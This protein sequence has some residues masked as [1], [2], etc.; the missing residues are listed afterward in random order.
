MWLPTIIIKEKKHIEMD[1]IERKRFSLD[2]MDIEFAEE[3]LEDEGYQDLKLTS[4]RK[5]ILATLLYIN[6]IDT[7]DEQGYFF[8]EN[9]YLCKLIGV[10]EPTLID[11]L[12]YFN[13]VGILSRIA[14][15]RGS[16]SL[17]KIEKTL[18]KNFSN[19]LSKN[20]SNNLSKNFSNKS[21]DNQ[22]VRELRTENF[23]NNLSKNFS[24]NFSNK[25][26]NFSTDTDIEEDKDIELD[27]DK[28]KDINKDIE[29]NN[30]NKLYNIKLINYLNNINNNIIYIKEKNIKKEKEIEEIALK[31]EEL[32]LKVDNFI[33]LNNNNKK[34]KFGINMKKENA[35]P[36]QEALELII[37]KLNSIEYRITSIE[38][39]IKT[40]KTQNCSV[41]A[42]NDSSNIITPIEEDNAADA[43]EM[44]SEAIHI[45]PMEIA[46]AVFA[47]K[48]KEIE[49]KESKIEK[50]SI[51]T[52]VNCEVKL[53]QK[54]IKKVEESSTKA[55]ASDMTASNNDSGTIVPQQENKP[56]QGKR[57]T[58]EEWKA[59]CERNARKESTST[60]DVYGSK[61]ASGTTSEGWINGV[62]QFTS[63]EDIDKEI[64]VWK[65][66]GLD[67]MQI[68]TR[69]KVDKEKYTM[70]DKLYNPNK[71]NS[72]IEENS[73]KEEKIT[74]SE[75]KEKVDKVAEILAKVNKNTET[76]AVEEVHKNTE[77]DA[78]YAKTDTSSY[79]YENDDM[80]STENALDAI[81]SSD[82]DEDIEEVPMNN[83]KK[84]ELAKRKE[85][86]VVEIPF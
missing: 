60:R 28:E 32:N 4:K 12:K 80:T 10:S 1:K 86:A 70:T 76:E 3:I 42:S 64:A 31:L 13:S 48:D 73:K 34:D 7:K 74:P 72:Q 15:K 47:K 6:G 84:E 83:S 18:V 27:I 62:K 63:M 85:D 29:K 40:L 53:K 35:T 36:T 67:I 81:F 54:D 50:R 77:R 49:E 8:V 20:F 65:G 24:N 68:A 56:L 26:K 39:E 16:A 41:T 17:Y 55:F 61:V 21:V 9:S 19:N 46:K 22:E 11:S 69:F 57:M 33:N 25:L 71:V 59:I 38:E 66:K 44:P 82:Y 14:G 23:S 37:T 75:S 2:E 30:I 79:E 51:P 58:D 45:N 43:K 52:F 78:Y 5:M